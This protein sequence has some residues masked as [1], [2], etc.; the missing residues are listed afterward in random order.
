[1]YDTR[2]KKF[3]FLFNYLFCV[4]AIS[5]IK[6]TFNEAAEKELRISRQSIVKDMF[7]YY[8]DASI[9]NFRIKVVFEGEIGEDLDGFLRDMFSSSCL[10]TGEKHQ[11]FLQLL[12]GCC[13]I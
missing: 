5:T 7:G 9:L 10:F 2:V 8:Q 6:D 1:M 12:E 13:V 3:K 4:S 11:I